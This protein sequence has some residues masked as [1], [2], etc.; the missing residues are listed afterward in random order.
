MLGAFGLLL[1]LGLL[2]EPLGLEL[3]SRPTR[4]RP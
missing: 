3:V 2:A 4:P 1:G